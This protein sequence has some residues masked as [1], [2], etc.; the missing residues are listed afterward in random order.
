M[1]CTACSTLT[2][3]GLVASDE[4]LRMYE[5][6]T[7]YGVLLADCGRSPLYEYLLITLYLTCLDLQR[8]TF[9]LP[10]ELGVPPD[11]HIGRSSISAVCRQ[12]HNDRLTHVLA[13]VRERN[14][15]KN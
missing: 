7:E 11:A 2:Q 4:V 10:R 6:C 9:L 12:D 13:L 14:G 5:A 8:N 3:P 1:R 15:L